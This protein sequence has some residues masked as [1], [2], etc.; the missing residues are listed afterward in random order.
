MLGQRGRQLGQ[1]AT[2]LGGGGRQNTIK[3]YKITPPPPSPSPRPGLS[4]FIFEIAKALK[5][6]YFI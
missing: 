6:L 1:F 3:E 5:R 4:F 2:G